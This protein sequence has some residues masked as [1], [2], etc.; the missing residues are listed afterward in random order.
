MEALTEIIYFFLES[1]EV[2]L[3]WLQAHIMAGATKATATAVKVKT[4]LHWLSYKPP[5]LPL[6]GVSKKGGATIGYADFIRDSNE[7]P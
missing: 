1:E 6:D 5:V 7:T 3:E 4:P 2:M